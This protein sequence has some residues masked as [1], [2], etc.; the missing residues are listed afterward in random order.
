MT[1]IGAELVHSP[2]RGVVPARPRP[3]DLGD[4]YS[5]V[6]RDGRAYAI[7]GTYHKP[8]LLYSVDG[9]SFVRWNTPQVPG[10]R[11][12]EIHD[13]RV[14]I[15]GEYGTIAWT[16][17]EGASWNT[18]ATNVNVCLYWI[19]RGP[20]GWLWIT[21]DSG[22]VWKTKGKTLR[23]VPTQTDGRVFQAFFDPLDGKPWLLDS[24]GAIQRWRGQGFETVPAKAMRAPRPLCE[25]MRTHTGTLLV[26]GDGGMI[27]R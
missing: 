17:T 11:D 9:R 2:S 25:I 16:D 6:V 5:L 23:R 3:D 15:T 8:T 19:E 18:I 10:L 7:G 12:V 1:T 22:L 24:S 14:W 13:G 26:V 21:G 4:L 27:L 20:G